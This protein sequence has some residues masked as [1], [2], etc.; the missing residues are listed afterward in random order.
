LESCGKAKDT[1]KKVG[2]DK[3][4]TNGNGKST[5]NGEIAVMP[6]KGKKRKLDE[7]IS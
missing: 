7:G 3:D 1:G 5:P 4:K 6:P 2:N